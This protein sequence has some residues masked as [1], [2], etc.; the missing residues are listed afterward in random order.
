HALREEGLP[1][2][3][4]EM[5]LEERTVVR[6]VAQETRNQKNR[7]AIAVHAIEELKQISVEQASGPVVETEHSW[8]DMFWKFAESV[9]DDDFQSIW[10][11]VLTRQVSGGAKYSARCLA[12]LSTI[13]RREAKLLEAIAGLCIQIDRPPLNPLHLIMTELSPQAYSPPF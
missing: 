5:S 12:T 13:S 9:S 1:A 4:A 6:I 3:G 8:L 7:E 10:G 2:Q 11:R